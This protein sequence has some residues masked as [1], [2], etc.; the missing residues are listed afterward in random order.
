[1]GKGFLVNARAAV[2][3]TARLCYTKTW[4]PNWKNT[5]C[6]L[7]PF[8]YMTQCTYIHTYARSPNISPFEIC[9]PCLKFVNTALHLP[10]S[11]AVLSS[12]TKLTLQTT[13]TLDHNTQLSC[14]VIITAPNRV[15][16]NYIH[17]TS[18][19]AGSRERTCTRVPATAFCSDSSVHCT[20]YTT[21]ASIPNTALSSDPLVH[22][23]VHT[24]C[25]C[26]PTTAF[27]SESSTRCASS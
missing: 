20:V 2:V 23:T 1:M 3:G 7:L 19:I 14:A 6:L 15:A 26:I 22:S 11:P 13:D 8:Y 9:P 16:S 21:C 17:C 25:G 5:H 4:S 10:L 27:S 18:L 12:S 24:I